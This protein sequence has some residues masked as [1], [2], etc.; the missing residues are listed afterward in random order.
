[1]IHETEINHK[2]RE[3]IKRLVKN[4][5]SMNNFS[6]F[7]IVYSA[8]KTSCWKEGQQKHKTNK[9]ANPQKNI[10]TKSKQQLIVYLSAVGKKLKNN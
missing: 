10:K 5:N 4:W 9:R 8:Y 3:N 2:V 7:V 1:M 6:V